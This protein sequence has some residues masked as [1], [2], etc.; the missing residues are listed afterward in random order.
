VARRDMPHRTKHAAKACS[1]E[2][3]DMP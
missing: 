2:T 3:P 1:I